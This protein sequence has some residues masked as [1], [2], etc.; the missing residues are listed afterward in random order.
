AGLA[1]VDVGRTATSWG[2]GLASGCASTPDADYSLSSPRALVWYALLPTGYPNFGGAVS[3]RSSAYIRF[4][5]PDGRHFDVSRDGFLR[6]DKSSLAP[7][8]RAAARYEAYGLLRESARLTAGNDHVASIERCKRAAELAAKAGDSTLAE[9]V[10]RVKLRALISADRREEAQRTLQQLAASDA[11]D[12]IAFDGARQMH[13]QGWL[14]DAIVWYEAG[15]ARRR[16]TGG[17]RMTY[18]YLEGILLALVEQQR[19]GDAMDAIRRYCEQ[20]ENECHTRDYYINF[21]RWM[22]GERPA[23]LVAT[24][25]VVDLTRYW[26]L[27]FRHANQE[28]SRTLLPAVRQEIA[29]AGTSTPLLK[30]LEALLLEDIGDHEAAHTAAQ[31]ALEQTTVL[32]ATDTA[33]RAHLEV[34]R[35]RAQRIVGSKASSPGRPS[36]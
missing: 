5:Y 6:S 14:D 19:W 20:Y 35:A 36:L 29:R 22:S 34:V 3:D 28:D 1:A 32:R 25:N 31:R 16:H 15:L 30:S 9:W 8:E 11:F 17:G 23:A 7:R 18:E 10:E 13:L 4:E 26:V 12:D 33:A 2:D 21:V 24:E 27:E